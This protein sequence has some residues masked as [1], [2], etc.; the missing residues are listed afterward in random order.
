MCSPLATLPAR[1]SLGQA[2]MPPSEDA[3]F[4]TSGITPHRA[5]LIALPRRCA[6]ASLMSSAGAMV[7]GPVDAHDRPQA[8]RPGIPKS[9]ATCSLSLPPIATDG[10][11][12]AGSRS[13]LS[14]SEL[15]WAVLHSGTHVYHERGESAE[16]TNVTDHPGIAL[17]LA[18]VLSYLSFTSCTC[19]AV[20]L[21]LSSFQVRWSRCC[22]ETN[23]RNEL[24][25]AYAGM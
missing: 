5:H 23:E 11:P 6:A 8:F 25:F 4:T 7:R 20:A 24:C 13:R 15:V 17:R 9:V 16:P 14:A 18:E 1:L 19:V 12:K 21:R 22:D 2:V 3:R 10:Q